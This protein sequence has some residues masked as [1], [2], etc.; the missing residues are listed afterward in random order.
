MPNILLHLHFLVQL[1]P[2]SRT[3]G[4]LGLLHLASGLG[5]GWAQTLNLGWQGLPTSYTEARR[6]DLVGQDQKG[7]W[8]R[9]NGKK[10]QKLE[11]RNLRME[12]QQ[13]VTLPDYLHQTDKATVL[14]T[15]SGMHLCLIYSIQQPK[16]TGFLYP[17]SP[18]T[19]T[20]WNLDN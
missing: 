14:N 17:K 7:F 13:A 16:N 18:K 1:N 20:V 11:Y 12:L 8:L 15:D 2:F 3:I 6:W 19:A 9:L 4:L 5:L 10:E